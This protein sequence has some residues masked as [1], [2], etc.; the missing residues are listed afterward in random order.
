M[1]KFLG[2]VG[3]AVAGITLQSVCAINILVDYT[4]D[5]NKKCVAPL[6]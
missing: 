4:Y 1:M 6:M 5:T 3:V 2:G